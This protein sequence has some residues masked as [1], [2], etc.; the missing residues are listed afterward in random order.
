MSE[1]NTEQVVSQDSDLPDNLEFRNSDTSE[2]GSS[3]HPESGTLDGDTFPRDYVVKLR[4]ENAKYRQR[5]QDRDEIATRL[6]TALVAATGRLADPSDL[7]FDND[8]IVDPN[9]MVEAIDALLKTKPHLATRKPS[10][11]I[12]QGLSGVS[13]TFSLSALLKNNAS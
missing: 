1:E 2:F 12:G 10:G 13:D 9:K 6:H 3:D 8:H 7:P 11:D 4:D 5:A